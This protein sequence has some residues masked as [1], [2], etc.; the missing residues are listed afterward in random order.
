MRNN[1][2]LKLSLFLRA[3]GPSNVRP[4]TPSIP[5]ALTLAAILLQPCNVFLG[6]TLHVEDISSATATQPLLLD[7]LS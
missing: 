4:A 3:L 7:T 2:A 1:T 6:N 5:N